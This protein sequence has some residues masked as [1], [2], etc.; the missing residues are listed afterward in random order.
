[1]Q[2]LWFI[3]SLI[4]GAAQGFT[5]GSWQMFGFGI[6]SLLIWPLSRWLKRTRDFATDGKVVFDGTDVWIGE[7]RLPRREIF[8]RKAWHQIVWDGLQLAANDDS[9]PRLLAEARRHRFVGQQTGSIWLGADRTGNFEFNLTSDG[10]HLLIIGATGTG[11]SEL[12]RLLVTGFLN[13]I[14]EVELTL[15]DF[16]GGATMAQFARHP[17]VIGLATDLI[18]THA[19]AIAVTLEKQ[20]IARQIELANAHSSSIEDFLAQG[21]SMRRQIIVI[22][23]LGELLRQHPRLAQVLEQ[24]ASRGR[25]LGMHLVLSNQS[26]AGISRT[27]LVNLRAKVAI[28][29][30]DPIDLVQLGFKS[31]ISNLETEPDWRAAKMKT[32]SG[33]ELAFCF[34]IGF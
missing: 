16:K 10:P 31:R 29:E 9:R 6:L 28:G 14:E 19:V 5:T 13:G 30:M 2:G 27:L 15:I 3:P 20:L 34:P 21:G 11:K 8:W 4:F 26:M 22:D 7:H 12:L 33:A 24:V 18:T 1:M 23:E 17:R 25:S 32:G